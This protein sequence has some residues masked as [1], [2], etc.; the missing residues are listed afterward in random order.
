M[1]CVLYTWQIERLNSTEKLQNNIEKYNIQICKYIMHKF[2][3]SVLW[4]S[5]F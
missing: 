2:K 3:Y 4:F 5:N 1:I